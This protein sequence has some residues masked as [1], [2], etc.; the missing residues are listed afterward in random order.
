[1]IEI[2]PGNMRNWKSGIIHA[3]TPIW[4]T[5]EEIPKVL[6]NPYNEEVNFHKALCKS[7]T[8]GDYTYTPDGSYIMSSYDVTCKRC[9]KILSKKDGINYG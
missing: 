9:L 7:E 3:A 1:M 5:W 8:R 4:K 2:R 6:R